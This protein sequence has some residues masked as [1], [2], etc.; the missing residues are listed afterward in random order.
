VAA[1][2]GPQ[3]FGVGLGLNL[4]LPADTTIPSFVQGLLSGI[5]PLQIWALIIT[6]FGVATLEKQTRAAAW[7]AA[8]ASYAVLLIVGAFFLGRGMAG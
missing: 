4:L 7:T 3:D 8:I 5:G 6:A 1:L 2:T